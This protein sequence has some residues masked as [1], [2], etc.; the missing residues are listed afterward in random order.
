MSSLSDKLRYIAKYPSVHLP[1]DI[2]ILKRAA[3]ALERLTSERD[4]LKAALQLIKANTNTID[5][6][7]DI[8]AAIQGAGK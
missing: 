5:W 3:D 7:D 8:N 6:P 4:A 1:D 2:G